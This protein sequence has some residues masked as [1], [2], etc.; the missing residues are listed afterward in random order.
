MIAYKFE[1]INKMKNF[2]L[3]NGTELFTKDNEARIIT[4]E[5][6]QFF[7]IC[8]YVVNAGDGLK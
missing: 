2:E 8:V 3:P 7:L 6:E 5:Y 1:S 4:F